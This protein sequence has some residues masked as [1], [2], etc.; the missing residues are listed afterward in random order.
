[1]DEL[2]VGDGSED[3]DTEMITTWQEDEPLEAIVRFAQYFDI[4]DVEDLTVQIIE[5]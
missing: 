5:I 1:M 4:V 2:I 3:R